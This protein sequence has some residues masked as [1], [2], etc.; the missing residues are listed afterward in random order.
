MQFWFLEAGTWSDALICGSEQFEVV[1]VDNGD[2]FSHLERFYRTVSSIATKFS[3][4]THV[5]EEVFLA[6]AHKNA[7]IF[8]T[9]LCVLCIHIYL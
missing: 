5:R 1:E 4:L 9:H 6:A 3:M 8:I 7:S 2:N